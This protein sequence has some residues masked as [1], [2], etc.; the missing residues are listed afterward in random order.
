[1]FMILMLTMTTN[2]SGLEQQVDAEIMK[3]PI[4]DVG[5]AVAQLVEALRYQPKGCWLDWDFVINVILPAAI[6]LWGGLSL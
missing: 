2:L 3:V 5:H 4:C 1:M 6:W